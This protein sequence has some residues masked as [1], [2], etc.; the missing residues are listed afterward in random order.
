MKPILKTI[1]NLFDPKQQWRLIGLAV[2]MMG[3]E[4]LLYGL[5]SLQFIGCGDPLFLVLTGVWLL[6]G[7]VFSIG[8][9]MVTFA[10]AEP[11]EDASSAGETSNVSPQTASTASPQT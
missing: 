5:Y 3:L 8:G 6:T 11:E 1:A 2:L 4:E 7:A 9:F 10:P